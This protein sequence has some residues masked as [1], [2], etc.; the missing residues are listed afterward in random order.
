[1]AWDTAGEGRCAG[2]RLSRCTFSSQ[3]IKPPCRQR[4]TLPSDTQTDGIPADEEPPSKL[5][6]LPIPQDWKDPALTNPL[7]TRSLP[8][9][10]VEPV[11]DASRA[12][13]EKR[14]RLWRQTTPPEAEGP[15]SAG[16]R[17]PAATSERAAAF[18]GHRSSHRGGTG[19]VP[20]AQGPSELSQPQGLSSLS[21]WTSA[22]VAPAAARRGSG[23]S[24]QLAGSPAPTSL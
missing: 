7:V 16:D 9:E 18:G 5:T 6:A 20:R 3:R 13:S 14:G 2:S 11:G 23:P 8:P 22:G 24:P 10:Q 12:G 17:D 1:M 21:R 4:L 19:G 15:P